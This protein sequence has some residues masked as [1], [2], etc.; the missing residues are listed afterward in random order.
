MGILKDFKCVICRTTFDADEYDDLGINK[1]PDCG[2]A[3]NYNE[4]LQLEL[5]AEQLEWLKGAIKP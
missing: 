3:Y 4:G 5:S 1:C 2:Q